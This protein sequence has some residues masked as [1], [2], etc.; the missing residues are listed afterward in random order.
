[1]NDKVEYGKDG[2]PLPAKKQPKTPGLTDK[3]LDKFRPE[4]KKKYA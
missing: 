2:F 4:G 3:E 1:M